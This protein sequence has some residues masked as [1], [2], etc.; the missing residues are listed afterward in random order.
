MS[1][2]QVIMERRRVGDL[3]LLTGRMIHEPRL[4]SMY[5]TRQLYD[6]I[7]VNNTGSDE[8]RERLGFLEAD[9]EIFITYKS[10]WP[11]YL[12]LLRPTSDGVW[13]IKSPNPSPGIRVFGF[14]AKKDTFIATHL[15]LRPHLGGWR[16]FKW[17]R[18]VRRAKAIWRTLF[19]PYT[20]IISD[21]PDDSFTGAIDENYFRD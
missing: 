19:Q 3:I 1:I 8:E 12:C 15:A 9:L 11:S 6:E 10:L 13:E 14:F 16:S 20:P 4:R 21:D 7:F 2:S 18:E 17:K 5:L